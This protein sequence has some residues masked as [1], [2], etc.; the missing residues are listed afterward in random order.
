MPIGL[1]AAAALIGQSGAAPYGPAAPVKPAAS[2]CPPPIPDPKTG[3]IVVCAVKPQGFR[4]DPDILAAKEAK[5]E[6]RAGRHKPPENLKDHSCTVVGAAPCMD[7]PM[8]NLPGAVA[9]AVQMGQR[10]AKGQ[11]IGS[12]FVTDPQPSEYQLYLQ[13]KK[14]REE[15]EADA[16]AKAAAAQAKAASSRSSAP[17]K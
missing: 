17:T 10:L 7:A 9:T 1:I 3:E 14:E 12:M 13:A 5:R 15:K 8:I 16:A 11:E 6:A 4:I 2:Q